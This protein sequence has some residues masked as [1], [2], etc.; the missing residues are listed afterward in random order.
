VDLLVFGTH[1]QTSDAYSPDIRARIVQ[2]R[3]RA[4]EYRLVRPALSIP[5]L[6]AGEL[7]MVSAA[8]VG[9]EQRLVGI[10][11]APDAAALA[12]MYVAEL[13]PCYEWE[14]FHDCP[15][16]DARFADTYQA[17]HPKGPFSHY[18]PLL[19]AHRWLCAAEL[20]DDPEQNPV[21]ARRSRRNYEQ[22]LPAALASSSL[23][24]RTAAKELAARARCFPKPQ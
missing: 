9:Y 11:E 2:F 17:A 18:L 14:G 15:E 6:S 7:Q 13:R 1:V 5:G 22:R 12:R 4:D 16:R 19:A 21:E 3:L 23:L 8:W 20:Y 24:V 10:S